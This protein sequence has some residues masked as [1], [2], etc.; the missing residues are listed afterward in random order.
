MN[1]GLSMPVIGYGVYQMPSGSDTE[2]AILTALKLGYRHIDSAQYYGNEIDVGNAIRRS[3]IPREEIF[4]VSKMMTVS[5]TSPENAKAETIAA[6]DDSLK[7]MGLDYID[8]YLL[9]S[10]HQPKLRA[11]RWA[12][13]E[14]CVKA[15]KVKSIGVSNYGVHHL[16]ELLEYC[17]IKPVCNQIEANPFCQRNEIREF[18]KDQGIIVVAY[19]PLAQASKLEDKTL[20]QIIASHLPKKIT[21]AQIMLRWCLQKGLVIIPKTV[22]ST[23]MVENLEA[24]LDD[25]KLTTE[26]IAALDKLDEDLTTVWNPT[27]LP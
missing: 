10:P 25:K 27:I 21:P 3:G 22:S 2:E 5:E 26:D 8:L 17:K 23:R 1:N 13:L 4:V 24:L 12:G 6:V 11:L 18:C 15:G 20:K 16:K 19:S 9:H 7:K 14:E